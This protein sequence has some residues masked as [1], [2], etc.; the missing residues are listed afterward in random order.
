MGITCT[1]CFHFMTINTSAGLFEGNNIM[2]SDLNASDELISAMAYVFG[3]YHISAN[4]C[5]QMTGWRLDVSDRA[6]GGSNSTMG[7]NSTRET[8]S[9]AKRFHRRN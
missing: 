4:R 2:G 1:D 3:E 6:L 9:K 8:V 5:P 7:G